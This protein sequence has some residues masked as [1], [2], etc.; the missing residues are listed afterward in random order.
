MR[1]SATPPFFKFSLYRARTEELQP[2]PFG[3]LVDALAIDTGSSDADRVAVFQLLDAGDDVAG[4]ATDRR[5][6]VIEEMI[7]LI[8]RAAIAGP[9]LLVLDDVHWSDPSSIQALQVLCRRLAYLP[10]LVLM[11]CRP[12]PRSQELARLLD[13]L[14][15]AGGR[16]LRLDPLGIEA[17]TELAASKLEADPGPVLRGRL[18]S[19]AGNPLFVLEFLDAL[20]EEG[21]IKIEANVA[22]ATAMV[23]PPPSL[24]MTML[25]RL[26]FL[27][28]AALELLR[29]ASLF[30]GSFSAAQLSLVT[31]TP[32]IDVLSNLEEPIAS[33]FVTA[34]GEAFTF[35]HDVV[36]EALY[37]E[38]PAAMRKGLH[39]H[40][41][42]TLAAAGAPPAEVANHLAIGAEFGDQN[43]V[44]WLRRAARELQSRAPAMT[45]QLLERASSLLPAEDPEWASLVREEV[46]SLAVAGRVREAEALAGSALARVTGGPNAAPL[47]V[48]R[49]PLLILQSRFRGSGGA[50]RAPARRCCPSHRNACRGG[51]LRLRRLRRRRQLQ[52]GAGHRRRTASLHRRQSHFAGGCVVCACSGRQRGLSGI[53]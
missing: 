24:R 49:V 27:S 13:A 42:R 41:G 4:E 28:P 2:R 30:G 53:L 50:V 7:N 29:T 25:R 46:R 45:V 8:E 3:L 1:S 26:A 35:R 20:L 48:A 19:A 17:V 31:G 52:Q 6:P 12:L 51:S 14:A 23:E 21:I 16:H 18:E 34:S 10:I 33:G 44:G 39:L 38:V 11:A 15:E 47:A 22:E 5:Y 43:A 36:R 32:L 40:V 37:L 9:V